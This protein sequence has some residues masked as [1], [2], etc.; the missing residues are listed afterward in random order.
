MCHIFSGVLLTNESLMDTANIFNFLKDICAEQK[1][2]PV[3]F[4]FQNW[5]YKNDEQKNL[6]LRP[7][8]SLGS[9]KRQI[10]GPKRKIVRENISL[11]LM[12]KYKSQT[13]DKYYIV[14]LLTV[15]L[16]LCLYILFQIFDLRQRHRLINY[17]GWYSLYNLYY[18][19]S[20][21][22]G[23]PCIIYTLF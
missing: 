6:F 23:V 11:T 15:F 19:G 9:R 10:E 7:K 2:S 20:L 3:D 1:I 21:N 17:P 13:F 4:S 5:T 16:K 14:I 22:R 8:N 18:I 12:V